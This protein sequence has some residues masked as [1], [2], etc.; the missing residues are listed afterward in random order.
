[1]IKMSTGLVSS[2]APAWLPDNCLLAMSSHMPS[3]V[4]HVSLNVS[5]FPYKDTNQIR[6]GATLMASL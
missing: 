1:M 5:K 3:C 2:E 6:L 4:A